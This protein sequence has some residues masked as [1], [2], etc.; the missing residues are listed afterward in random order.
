[1]RAVASC[2]SLSAVRRLIFLTRNS[3]RCRRN[4][5]AYRIAG[6]PTAIRHLWRR[7]C[8]S[9][10]AIR[11]A[12]AG[13]FWRPQTAA[14]T[15]DLLLALLLWP[16]VLLTLS[17]VS[18]W[19][20][21]G[22]IAVRSRRSFF[23]Q[24]LDQFRL[25]VV[26]GVLPPMYYVY[27]F[28]ERP[29][30]RHA[31]SFLFRCETKGGVYGIVN[32]G[33]R[34][35]GSIVNDKAAFTE[36]CRAHGIPS[37]PTLAVLHSGNL[38][39]D[40]PPEDFQTDLFIKPVVAKGGRGTQRWDYVG[41]DLHRNAQGQVLSKD[42]LFRRLMRKSVK[43]PLLIQPRIINH[44]DLLPISNGALST[45]R[46]LTCLDERND[47][48]LIGAVLRMAIGSNHVIDNAHAGGIAAAVN[49]D[50][51]ILGLASDL[52]MNAALGWLERHP[53]SGAQIE[54]VM[55]PYWQSLRTFVERAHSTLPGA[56]LLG[57]DVAIAQE[58]II[59][60]EANSGPG[61]E[62]MQR[63]HHRGFS[64]ERLGQLLAHHLTA[65]S[66]APQPAAV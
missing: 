46:V 3:A 10:A 40:R 26:A 4:Q 53:T 17:C 55:L 7:N 52:G 65:R 47:P 29:R 28:Y 33:Q 48:E 63:A 66:Q 58:G 23:R 25:Y 30:R 49:L 50:T 64:R 19:R 56:I 43:R 42:K 34:F 38:I 24:L 16:L 11:L 36:H 31:R 8:N 9:A 1:M 37:V 27:E 39:S 6:L 21:G 35:A 2:S 57:W 13:R 14:E 20:N 41:A 45:I 51:G 5:L 18:L 44:S 61:L 60:I 54:G 12:Y 32:H 62:M 15:F 59:L 22:A